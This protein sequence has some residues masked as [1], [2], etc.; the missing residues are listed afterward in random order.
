[1]TCILTRI[2]GDVSSRAGYCEQSAF[3]LQMVLFPMMIWMGAAG[4][5]LLEIEGATF[6]VSY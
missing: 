4:I 6:V 1:M 5:T 2:W 3:A